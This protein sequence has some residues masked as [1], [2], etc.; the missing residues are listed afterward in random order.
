MRRTRWT[1]HR[2]VTK[3]GHGGWS[4]KGGL[5][6]TNP[7][8]GDAVGVL[9]G[10]WNQLKGIPWLLLTRRRQDKRRRSDEAWRRHLGR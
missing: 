9:G 6:Y 2:R 4:I 1:K 5:Q 8:T 10:P 7:V 3:P